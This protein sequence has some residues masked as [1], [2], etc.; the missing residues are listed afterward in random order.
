MPSFIS[1]RPTVWPQYTNVTDRQWSDSTEANH[2]TNG[3][4]K[5]HVQSYM[6]FSVHVIPMAMAQSCSDNSAVCYI[7]PVLWMTSCFCVIG[8]VVHM[9][10]VD[11]SQQQAA[12]RGAE[13]KH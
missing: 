12:Q 11:V 13:L 7:L 4:R 10:H 8:H 6:K 5:P 1:I 9:V 3:R 2:F